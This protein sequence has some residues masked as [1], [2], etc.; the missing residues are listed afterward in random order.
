MLES[1]PTKW[2]YMLDKV[3]TNVPLCTRT[4]RQAL[5]SNIDTMSNQLN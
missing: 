5:Q 4:I 2:K 1:K 3:A